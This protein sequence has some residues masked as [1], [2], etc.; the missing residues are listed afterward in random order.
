M[1]SPQGLDETVPDHN[2]GTISSD[3]AIIGYDD[4]DA[5]SWPTYNLTTIKRPL[6]TLIN[7]SVKTIENL[8]NDPSTIYNKI[9]PVELIYRNSL[10]IKQE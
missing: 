6:D 5:A 10:S 3:V 1:S 2:T 7:E 9:I 8:I 4:I